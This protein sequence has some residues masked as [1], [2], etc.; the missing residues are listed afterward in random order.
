MLRLKGVSI[1]WESYARR[2]RTIPYVNPASPKAGLVLSRTASPTTSLSGSSHVPLPKRSIPNP[3]E[4]LQ[5]LNH[6]AEARQ[7]MKDASTGAEG[8]GGGGD[9]GGLSFTML[10]RLIAE[11]RTSEVP[12]R[13][14]PEGTNV[15]SLHCH[16]SIDRFFGQ[17]RNSKATAKDRR[18]RDA[19][20]IYRKPSH[21]E[22]T[23][24][25]DLNPGKWRI[26]SPHL[27]PPSLTLTDPIYHRH[28]NHMANTLQVQVQP[29]HTDMLQHQLSTHLRH[30]PITRLPKCGIGRLQVLRSH[31]I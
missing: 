5:T 3:Q 29:H 12:M 1:P 18:L 22:P 28:S 14:I 30:H 11:G 16:C 21:N 2:Q 31:L 6:L 20:M 25:H 8:A 9:D 19:D 27:H 15:S 13:Q 17:Y 4:A 7:M 26:H 23:Y 10:S 24:Q